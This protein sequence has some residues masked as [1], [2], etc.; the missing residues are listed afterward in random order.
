MN[1]QPW[2]SLGA[3]FTV[4]TVATVATL[5][6]ALAVGWSSFG[7]DL[8]RL[9]GGDTMA[10]AAGAAAVAAIIAGLIVG[11]L[12][13]TLVRKPVRVL[14]ETMARITRGDVNLRAGLV[15]RGEFAS[16]A[17]NMNRM[18]DSVV[19]TQSRADIDKLTGLFNFRHAHNYLQ[20][21]VGLAARYDRHLTIGIIDIDHFTEIN[22]IYGHQFGDEVL[23]NAAA[24][25]KTQLRQ[26]DYLARTG[27]EEFLVVLPETPAA[28]AMTVLERIHAGFSETVFVK[29][30]DPKSPVFM[31]AGVADFPRS[32]EDAANLMASAKMALLLA[33]RRGRNQ[34]AYFRSLD[35]KAS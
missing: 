11:R 4:F 5:G 30:G 10:A 12:F 15:G 6:L 32:G 26:V 14:N 33:K 23:K 34:V 3:K 20:T 31:S 25:I 22:D 2:F 29:R 21:Q 27:G 17:D 9:A 18:I 1:R 7:T 35:Q 13:N 16:L 8:V 19:L 28:A 24:Y